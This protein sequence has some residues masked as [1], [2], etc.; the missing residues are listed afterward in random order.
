M[1]PH[2]ASV[3]HAFLQTFRAAVHAAHGRAFHPAVLPAHFEAVPAARRTPQSRTVLPAVH[4]SDQPADLL[5]VRATLWPARLRALCSAPEPPIGAALCPARRRAQLPAQL[6]AAAR[7]DHGSFLQTHLRALAAARCTAHDAAP[8]PAVRCA[9][10][11]ARRSS[12]ER[13]L[14]AAQ[15]RTQLAAEAQAQRRALQTACRGAHV[16][17]I[18]GPYPGSISPAIQRP[19]PISKWPTYGTTVGAPG[20]QPYFAAIS[21]SN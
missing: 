4:I 8:E 1:R 18:R 11:A 15:C 21:P 5:S 2:L 14:Q 9:V 19:V 17:A 10:S 16:A 12:F 20:F 3:P 7:S 13:A 6:P